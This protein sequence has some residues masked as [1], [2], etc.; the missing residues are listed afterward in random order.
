MAL[1]V[2]HGQFLKLTKHS[3]PAVFLSALESCD[4]HKAAGLLVSMVV[5]NGGLDNTPLALLA[6]H[7]KT[8][9]VS[10]QAKVK[11]TSSVTNTVNPNT[12]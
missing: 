1:E 6:T 10:L 4:P 9:L 3:N 2:K 11:V 5:S 8:C 7:V 12:G